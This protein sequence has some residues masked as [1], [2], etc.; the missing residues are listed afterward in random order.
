MDNSS[1]VLL[2]FYFVIQVMTWPFKYLSS[3]IYRWSPM[4][5]SFCYWPFLI[6]HFQYFRQQYSIKDSTCQ[7]SFGG[8]T[9][10]SNIL[11]T[12][13]RTNRK[14]PALQQRRRV[15]RRCQKVRMFCISWC[16]VPE[17]CNRSPFK[18]CHVILWTN[19]QQSQLLHC[20]L[21]PSLLQ[22]WANWRFSNRWVN[23][24]R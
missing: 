2:T 18:L 3:S 21:Q 19:Q 22:S 23:W 11:K 1:R 15:T 6:I 12:G 7:N 24:P 16:S 4:Y 17:I 20:H 8:S 5:S 14:W 10:G 13:R 9:R